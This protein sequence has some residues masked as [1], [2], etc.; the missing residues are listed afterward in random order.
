L[1]FFFDLIFFSTHFP[2]AFSPCKKLNPQSLIC[3]EGTVT[4]L[5]KGGRLHAV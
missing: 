1:F 3:K 2:W 4:E 5:D